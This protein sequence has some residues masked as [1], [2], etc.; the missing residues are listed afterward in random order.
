MTMPLMTAAWIHSIYPRNDWLTLPSSSSIRPVPNLFNHWS[1][2]LRSWLDVSASCISKNHSWC[3]WCSRDIRHLMLNIDEMKTTKLF[4][5]WYIHQLCTEHLSSCGHV[6][7]KSTWWRLVVC[8]TWFDSSRLPVLEAPELVVSD[9]CWD[10]SIALYFF[11]LYD[12]R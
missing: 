11:L 10:T 12:L 3:S 5:I 8:C 4:C 6:S 7:R 2:L 1:S 9:I